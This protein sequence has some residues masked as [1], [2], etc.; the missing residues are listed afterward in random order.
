MGQGNEFGVPSKKTVAKLDKRQL[1]ELL[2]YIE[3]I[4]GMVP[5]GSNDWMQLKE[6]IK[7]LASESE[8]KALEEFSSWFLNL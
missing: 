4:V 6:Q 8:Y 2:W 1:E 5:A 3:D 7:A